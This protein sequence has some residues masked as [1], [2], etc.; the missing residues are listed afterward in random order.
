M[1]WFVA[2]NRT[3]STVVMIGIFIFSLLVFLK[4]LFLIPPNR[5]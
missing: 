3:L 2:G 4:K 5:K 1:V